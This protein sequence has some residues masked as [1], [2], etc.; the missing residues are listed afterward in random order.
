M[1]AL[2]CCCFSSRGS[3]LEISGIAINHLL[4][5]EVT[6]RRFDEEVVVVA[7]QAVGAA[8]PVGAL[9]GLAEDG[10][11][12]LAVVIFGKDVRPGVAARGDVVNGT[13]EFYA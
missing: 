8:K 9:Y 13:G 1:A 3:G 12:E 6:L 2:N 11:E 4:A 7:H 5:G 10:K